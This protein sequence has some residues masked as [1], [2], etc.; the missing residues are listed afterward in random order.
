MEKGKLIVIEGTDC[1]GKETQSK[2]LIDRLNEEGI[3]T[4]YYSFPKYD[5]PTGKMVGLPYLGKPY[6]ANE[7]IMDEAKQIYHNVS[8]SDYSVD[9]IINILS[10]IHPKP[11]S[12]SEKMLIE[13]TLDEVL[14]KLSAR[15]VTLSDKVMIGV[16]LNEV[17]NSLSHGWFK[18]G[19]PVVDPKVASLFYAADRRYNL[20]EINNIL[21]NGSNIILDRYTYS[22]MAHQ[23]GKITDPEERKKMFKWIEALEFD[24]LELPPSD[25]RIFLHMPTDYAAILKKS[26]EEKLD[27]HESDP[28]HLY[29]AEQAYLELAS[30]YDFDTIECI[31]PNQNE[32]PLISDIKTPE[33]ISDEV[34][35]CVEKKLK[36]K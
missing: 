23:G 2:K 27:E 7:M 5:T 10:S 11:F 36:L 32:N 9:N 20:P 15:R 31:R 3:N 8:H 22:S 18:E 1:S 12:S 14:N 19:A 16:I 25:A 26:R 13:Y 29:N 28:K 21:A 4:Q 17:I 33:E 30:L 34:Y 35:T 6:L 24:F